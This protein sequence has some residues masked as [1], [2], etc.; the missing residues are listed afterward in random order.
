MPRFP[1]LPPR[2]DFMKYFEHHGALVKLAALLL[3]VLLEW[4]RTALYVGVPVSM[5]MG[6]H[7]WLA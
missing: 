7:K 5:A 2:Q 6:L 3:I 4:G 1:K